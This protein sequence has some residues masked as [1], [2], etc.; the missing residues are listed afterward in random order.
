MCFTNKR[1]I[2]NG[3]SDNSDWM[4]MYCGLLKV[5]VH[6]PNKL[7]DLRFPMDEIEKFIYFY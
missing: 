3:V 4:I 6:Y 1:Y 5:T 7:T 2:T